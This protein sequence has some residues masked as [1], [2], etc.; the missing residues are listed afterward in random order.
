MLT[1]QQ[2][3]AA[4]RWLCDQDGVDPDAQTGHSA[5]PDKD[6]YV[7]G[8]QLYSPAW[9]FKAREISRWLQIKESVAPA[10][11]KETK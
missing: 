10:S 2:I 11:F 8:V 9:R 5:P 3:E 1:E 6:G 7:L 4:A